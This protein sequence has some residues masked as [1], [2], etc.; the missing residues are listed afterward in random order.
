MGAA[1]HLMTDTVTY[2][3]ISSKSNS[4]DPTYG[5]QSTCAARVEHYS[6]LVIGADGNEVAADHKVVSETEIKLTYRVWLPGD[7]VATANSARRVISVSKATTP[8]GYTLYEA[9]L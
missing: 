4:G 3:A 6:K 2:A 1:L 5:S 8:S 7:A 9:F